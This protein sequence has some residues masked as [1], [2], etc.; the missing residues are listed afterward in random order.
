[1]NPEHRKPEGFG[2]VWS[3]IR[4]VSQEYERSA[5]GVAYGI[6]LASPISESVEQLPQLIDA[7]MKVAYDVEWARPVSVVKVRLNCTHDYALCSVFLG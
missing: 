6:A 4:K 1:L 3:S 5:T 7:A 2:I